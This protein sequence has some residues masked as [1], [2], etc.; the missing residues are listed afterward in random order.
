M[1]SVV[2]SFAWFSYILSVSTIIHILSYFQNDA[3]SSQL[4]ENVDY[5]VFT[6]FIKARISCTSGTGSSNDIPF[7]YNVI[8]DTFLVPSGSPDG[9]V[10][11][12]EQLFAVF[13]S[14]RYKA[15][16]ILNVRTLSGVL[17]LVLDNLYVFDVKP[18]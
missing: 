1:R 6:T 8:Q 12:E 18:H 16:V 11:S 13:N 7:H 15:I 17:L 2:R 14:A 3:G 4:G 9:S 5:N 10:G